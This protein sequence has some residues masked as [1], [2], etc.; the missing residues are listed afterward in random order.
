MKTYYRVCNIIQEKGLWYDTNGSF[1]GI[2]HKEYDFCGAS[3]LPMDFD[4]ELIGWLSAVEELD[5]LWGWFNKK[6]VKRLQEYNYFI[7]AFEAEEEK[8]YDNYKHLVIK[9]ET[10]TPVRK[11]TLL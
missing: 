7:Y 3:V 4:N 5:Q 6:E 11:I 9:Q 2:I 8:F 10:A 1:T